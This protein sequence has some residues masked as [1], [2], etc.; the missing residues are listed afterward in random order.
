MSDA[1]PGRASG[2]G[3]ADVAR[4]ADPA[5]YRGRPL[6]VLHG[7][8]EI[9]GQGMMLA[10][11]LAENGCEAHSLAYA[12][13]YDARRPDFIVELDQHRTSFGKLMAMS[14]AFLRWGSHFDVYHL[15]FG[16]SF[17]GTPFFAPPRPAAVADAE[18]RSARPS[19]RGGWRQADLPLLRAKGKRIAFHFHGCEVRNRALMMAAHRL[20]TCTECEPFCLPREQ[21]RLRTLAAKY[22]DRSFYSTLDLAE[23]VPNGVH[24]PLAIEAERWERAALDRPLPEFDRRDGVRAPVVIAHAHAPKYGLLKGTRYIEEAVARLRTEF[25][26]V[27]LRLIHGQPWATMPEFLS[28][29]DI[30]VDQVMMGWYGLLAI[31]GM[32]ERRAVVSYL[33]EDLRPQYPDCPIVSAEPTTLYEVLRDLVRDPAR[34]AELGKRGARFA[35]ARHDTKVVGAGLLRIYREMLGLDPPGPGAPRGGTAAPR[36]AGGG[37]GGA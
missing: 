21:E 24:L 11:G 10:K 7:C 16:T 19:R 5:F 4:G 13:G 29:C 32:A 37:A 1:R 27:E 6:R 12:V 3:G 23:S 17:F 9:A 31:E 36:G 30:L 20:A 22:A 8:Y 15:H 33:R 14:R 2:G 28:G 35:R 26:R 34:R 25:P 18:A